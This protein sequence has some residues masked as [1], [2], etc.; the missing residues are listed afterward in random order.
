MMGDEGHGCHN[1]LAARAPSRGRFATPAAAAV[2]HS[3]SRPVPAVIQAGASRLDRSALGR[4]QQLPLSAG[5]RSQMHY[6]I[7][8]SSDRQ[9]T[10]SDSH[11][12]GERGGRNFGGATVFGKRQDEAAPAAGSC[13]PPPSRPYEP[14]PLLGRSAKP[15]TGSAAPSS[16]KK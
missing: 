12:F 9:A 3:I 14:V 6:V 2:C 1:D 16:E 15:A 7:I 5:T 11:L 4:G 13:E 8:K 10:L